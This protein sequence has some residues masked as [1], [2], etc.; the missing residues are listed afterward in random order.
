MYLL[1]RA[2]MFCHKASLVNHLLSKDTR[3]VAFPSLGSLSRSF[4]MGPCCR[5]LVVLCTSFPGSSETGSAIG[6]CVLKL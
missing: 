5:L 3:R 4:E 6:F 2:A 1:N